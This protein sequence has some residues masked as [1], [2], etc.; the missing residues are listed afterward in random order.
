MR[1]SEIFY[2]VQG[3]GS[4]IGVPSV[5]VRTSGCNLRCRWCDTRYSSWSPEGDDLP[6]ERIVEQVCAYPTRFCVLTGGEPMIASGLRELAERLVAAGKHLTIET[7]GT[8]AP[9]GIRCSLASLSPKLSN[10]CP[11]EE[12]PAEV[13]YRHERERLN[14]PALR[15]WI[16][17]YDHQLKFVIQSGADIEEVITYVNMLGVGDR[18]ERIFLVPEGHT[19]EELDSK[20]TVI[21][22]ACRRFGF[23]FGDRLHIRL[24][25]NKRGT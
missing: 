1:I 17:R 10:T 20:A 6:V 16:A 5:F 22:D 15:E 4:L 13:R 9:D 11:G 14:I 18:P 21:L 3:E 8:V 19:T 7:S 24:F 25:G 23:R 2:S 12:A